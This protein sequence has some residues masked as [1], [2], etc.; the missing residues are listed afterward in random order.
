MEIDSW[1]Q[2]MWIV[3]LCLCFLVLGFFISD[4][5]FYEKST[6]NAV[7]YWSTKVINDSNWISIEVEGVSPERI[8]EVSQHEIGHEL[9]WRKYKNNYSKDDSENFAEMCESNWTKCLEMIE[10]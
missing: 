4:Y 8:L 2:I 10:E 9:Y 6:N 3:C 7:G 1:I 5:G